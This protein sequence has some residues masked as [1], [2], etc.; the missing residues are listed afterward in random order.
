[1]KTIQYIRLAVIGAVAA[2]GLTACNDDD[3]YFDDEY[4]STPITVTKIFLEDYKSSVPDRE[5]DFGRL[6]QTLRIEG[7]GFMGLKKLYINGYDT[8]FNRNLVSDNSMLVSINSKT[9]IVEAEEDVRDIIRFVKDGTETSYRFVI[10]AAMPTVTAV[11]NTLPLPGEKVTVTGTGLQEISLVTLPGGVEVTEGIESDDVDGEWYSFTMPQGVTEAGALI[12]TGANGTAQSPAYF[13]DSRCMILNFDGVGVQGFWSWKENGSM[14][15]NEDL[16]DDPLGSRGKCFQVVPDRL[17]ADGISSAK[18]RVTECWT[19]GNDDASDDWN[20]MT[21]VI[22]PTTPVTEL[23]FQF[24]V[25]C[26]D[27]WNATGQIQICLINNY[28]FGGYTSDDNNAKSLTLF[29]IP[30]AETGEAFTA[31][32]W[33]TVTIPLSEMGKYK[34]IIEDGEAAVPTFADVIAD[35]NGASYR[36]FGMGFVNSDFTFNKAEFKSE[37]F[38]G[39]RIYTDNWRIVSCKSVTL[40]DFPEDEEEAE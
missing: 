4:Q 33:T 17:L 23:A 27:P 24:D 20:R 13:N 29:F 9:P 40:S 37:W 18:S 2:A 19:A 7:K 16:V 28:N 32:E 15:N 5:V 12:A 30:W 38:Y 8:Y 21:S 25:L 26:P 39:P 35:R 6:G 14:I 10:R 36:N 31:P 11:S 22:D 34:A 1:M 3:E